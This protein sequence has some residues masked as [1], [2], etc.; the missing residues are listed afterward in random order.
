M[1]RLPA[2]AVDIVTALAGFGLLVGGVWMWSRPAAMVLA[3]V[4]LLIAS[5]WEGRE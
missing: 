5:L 2:R 4:L 3:G 1:V